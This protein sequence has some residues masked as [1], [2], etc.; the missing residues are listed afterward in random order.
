MEMMF[1]ATYHNISVISWQS[2]LLVENLSQVTDTY[3]IMLYRI[4]FTMS[5]IQAHNFSSDRH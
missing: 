3:H 2:A 4:Q 5:G 1:N